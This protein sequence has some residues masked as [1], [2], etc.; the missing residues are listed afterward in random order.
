M[1]SLKSDLNPILKNENLAFMSCLTEQ[2]FF[3]QLTSDVRRLI[4][5][6]LKTKHCLSDVRAAHLKTSENKP[7][8]QGAHRASLASIF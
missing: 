6:L 1:S 8:N 2:R 3:S 5:S 7:Q 4:V